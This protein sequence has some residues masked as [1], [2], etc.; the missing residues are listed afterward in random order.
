MFA[1]AKPFPCVPHLKTKTYY[2]TLVYGAPLKRQKGRAAASRHIK[3]DNSG[4]DV[5]VAPEASAD[6][7]EEKGDGSNT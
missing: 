5:G 1:L 7:E 4:C 3:I 2:E 6:E